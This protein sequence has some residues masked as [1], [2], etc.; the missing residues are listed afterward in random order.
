MIDVKI[1][2][3]C[4]P[5]D[6]AL[7]GAAGATYVGVIL[8]PGWRRTRS[9]AEAALIYGASEARRVG[10]FVNATA[11][12]VVDAANRL[13]LDVVQLHG[14]EQPESVARLREAGGWQVWKA[15]PV[16]DAADITT[17]ATQY[18]GCA[19]GLL[20]EGW[21]ACAGGGAGAAF[22]WSVAA[23]ECRA[24]RPDIR[25]VVAGGLRPDNVAAAITTLQPGVV[26]VS[27]GVEDTAG[28]KSAERVQ[29][30]IAAARAAHRLTPAAP[31]ARREEHTE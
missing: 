28:R 18:A 8:A 22:A 24:L 7:A 30:F 13:R 12:M 15:I 29:A 19:D 16:R 11:E 4:H 21:S 1:C 10:V 20:L 17:G 27:S 23:A 14:S 25:V 5:S 3:V 6:A 31:P 9:I 2:G 26:D